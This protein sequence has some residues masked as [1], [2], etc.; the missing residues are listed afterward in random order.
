MPRLVVEEL[1]D[2][3]LGL[4]EEE[5]ILRQPSVYQ[6]ICHHKANQL[7]LLGGQDELEPAQHC[8]GQGRR[9]REG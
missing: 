5:E 3:E 2:L 7:V 1:E 8:P 6:A 4:A 9:G